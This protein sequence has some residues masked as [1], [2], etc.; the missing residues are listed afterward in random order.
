VERAVFA[1][2][3]AFSIFHRTFSIFHFIQ[4][5]RTCRCL[6]RGGLPGG[7]VA[8]ETPDELLATF[9]KWKMENGKW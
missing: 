1:A 9:S 6:D 3:K 2:R 7:I 4:L 8:Q 5:S